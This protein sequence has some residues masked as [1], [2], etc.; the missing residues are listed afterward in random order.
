M[1][2]YSLCGENI[3]GFAEIKSEVVNVGLCWFA[4]F[5][6]VCFDQ[7]ETV[8]PGSLLIMVY[9]FFISAH[10]SRRSLIVFS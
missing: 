2:M 9:F 8:S 4:T 10:Q 7:G 6:S 5:F 1:Q 3:E